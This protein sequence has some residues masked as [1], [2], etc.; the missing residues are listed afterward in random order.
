MAEVETELGALALLW[1]RNRRCGYFPGLR[2]VP[3]INSDLPAC[4]A[5]EHRL[6]SIVHCGVEYRFNFLRLSLIQQSVDPAFHLDSDAA[7]ALSGDVTTLRQRRVARLLLN[8]S[9]LRERVLHFLD[10]DPCCVDLISD[11]SYVRA[12]DPRR[13]MERSLTVVIPARRGSPSADSFSRPTECCTR[14]LTVRADTSWRPT[15]STKW[16]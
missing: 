3:G 7:T 16:I 2:G 15:A 4:R 13:L 11:G 10:V 12:A 8:L 14:V 6:P 9:L 5:F 1:M